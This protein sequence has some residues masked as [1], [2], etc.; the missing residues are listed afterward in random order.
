MEFKQWRRVVAVE[1]ELLNLKIWKD[2][3]WESP[4]SITG[5]AVFAYSM[6]MFS[7]TARQETV[8]TSSTHSELTALLRACKEGCA[9]KFFVME[10]L[11]LH[12]IKKYRA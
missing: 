2:G 9:F 6:L 12:P 7:R 3:T 11:G 1:W 8:A 5:V 10:L 4:K